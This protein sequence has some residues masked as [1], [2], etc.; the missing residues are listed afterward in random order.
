MAT[1]RDRGGKFHAQ[2]RMAGFP[3]RTGSFPTKRQAERWAKTVEAEMIEGRHFKNSAGRRRNMTEAAVKY[4]REV[5]HVDAC[6]AYQPGHE[7]EAQLDAFLKRKWVQPTH[8]DAPA[9]ARNSLARVMWWRAQLRDYK[10]GAVTTEVIEEKLSKLRTEPYQRS[11]PQQKNSIVHGQ[12]PRLMYR[13]EKT[14]NRYIAAGSRL[15]R[16]AHKRWHWI[17]SNPFA[18][19]ERTQEHGGRIK[20]LTTEQRG[21]LFAEIRSGQ[22]LYAFSSTA[23]ATVVRAGD[24]QKLR[25]IDV[26]FVEPTEK[27][28]QAIGRLAIQQP[29]NKEPRIVWISGEPLE[30]LRAYIAKSD[31]N[32]PRVFVSDTGKLYR[33][34]KAFVDACKRARITGFTFHG[35]RHDGATH[36][37]RLGATE[38]QLKAIGGWKSNVVAKYVHLAA[39]D[40]K[41]I[42][43]KMN[44]KVLGK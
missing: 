26:E 15:F 19:I 31:P 9:D 39:E 6:P 4:V 36:L 41:S 11:K 5:L 13:T 16:I 40:A 42:V 23:R 10:V 21:R 43:Q 38:Q 33:Y 7:Y 35:W 44:E 14:V 2:V 30:V 20:T 25:K 18:G 29:K 12:P 24:L 37:A 34:H 32:E 8:P 22:T 27:G 3:S 28:Q 17:T 1:I